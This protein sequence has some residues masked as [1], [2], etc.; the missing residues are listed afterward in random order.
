[1][2][3]ALK[4]FWSRLQNER[5]RFWVSSEGRTCN[6]CRWVNPIVAAGDPIMECRRHPP[7]GW[8]DED[9][10]GDWPDGDDEDAPHAVAVDITIGQRF[11]PVSE[12]DWCG[13]WRQ[14]R[15]WR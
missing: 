6:T 7:A 12:T 13:E 2:D 14:R 9:E 4:A 8:G 15:A 1:M 5:E 11:P 3:Q 10:W